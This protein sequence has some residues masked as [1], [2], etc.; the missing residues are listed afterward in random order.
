MAGIVF[1]TAVAVAL[2]VCMTDESNWP[3]DRGVRHAGI[4]NVPMPCPQRS[5]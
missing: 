2:L 4:A 1:F 3:W 5:W